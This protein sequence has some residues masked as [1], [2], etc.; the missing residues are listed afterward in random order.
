[1][2]IEETDL[3]QEV[4]QQEAEQQPQQEAQQQEEPEENPAYLPQ[5]KPR[6]KTHKKN[7]KTKQTLQEKYKP[8]IYQQDESKEDVEKYDRKVNKALNFAIQKEKEK[9]QSDLYDTLDKSSTIPTIQE[10]PE[11]PRNDLEDMPT[12]DNDYYD[13]P[14]EMPQTMTQEIPMEAPNPELSQFSL[15]LPGWQPPN[16]MEQEEEADELPMEMDYSIGNSTIQ[17]AE[18]MEIQQQSGPTSDLTAIEPNMDI[19]GQY[20]DPSVERSRRRGISWK[21]QTEIIKELRKIHGKTTKG[22]KKI[23]NTTSSGKYITTR[24]YEKLN[25]MYHN[26]LERLRQLPSIHDMNQSE[27]YNPEVQ[28]LLRTAEQYIPWLEQ[29]KPHGYEKFIK[30]LNRIK[31]T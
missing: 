6:K 8:R 7:K 13:L 9:S 17:Q 25:T 24:G 21:K 14:V 15:P 2:T 28:E 11:E 5:E 30:E 29:E 31:G 19:E 16:T 4:P 18:Q 3:P 12:E 23:G 20:T 10:E 22:M 26:T 1:M 27:Y